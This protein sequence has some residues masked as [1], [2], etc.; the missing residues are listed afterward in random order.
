MVK[1][2]LVACLLWRQGGIVQSVNFEHTNIIGSASIAVEFFNVWG[3]D[4][5]VLLDV[6]RTSNHREDFYTTLNKISKQCFVPLTVGGWVDSTDE[7]R[8]LLK[9]GADKVAINTAALKQPDLLTEASN[10]F[11][12][13]CVVASI[14]AKQTDD[15]YEAVIDRGREQTGQDAVELSTRVEDL[16]AGEIFLT[17]IDKDGTKE[18]YELDLI[19]DVT[20]RVSIPVVASGGAGEWN[21]LIEAIE[22]GNAD[23]VSVAN[24]FHHSQHSTTKAK[25]ALIEAGLDV[26]HPVFSDRYGG[27]SG[28]TGGVPD[29][30]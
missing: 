26:R 17:S 29:S 28:L 10:K 25:E 13:Q 6:S 30:H 19:R 3:I 4:E 24:R 14:D 23:A 20:D 16:G 5:I 12:T 18:G 21:H 22:Q 11:G 1:K 27:R 9:N 8:K 7:V 15:G 2:R